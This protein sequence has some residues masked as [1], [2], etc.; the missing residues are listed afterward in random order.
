[1]NNTKQLT[2]I[3]FGIYFILLAWIILMKTELSFDSIY[4]MQSLNLIPFAGTAVRN[5]QLDYQEIS[6]N[7]LIFLP[8]GLYLSML[9]PHWHFLQ[10]LLPVFLVSFLFES[11]QYVLSIGATDITDLL[12]NT[13]GGLLGILLYQIIVYGLKD[14][15]KAQRLFNLLAGLVT[16][17]F[18]LIMVAL[19]IVNA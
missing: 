4:R 18:F 14:H 1:M 11:L 9:K 7:I 13:L 12:G 2:R 16:F 5:N 3:L 17:L 19:F 6:L 10:K 15:H 8:F